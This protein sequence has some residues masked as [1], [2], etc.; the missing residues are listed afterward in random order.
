MGPSIQ[1][2][3]SVNFCEIFISL[4]KSESYGCLC[5]LQEFRMLIFKA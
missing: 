4:F 1:N 3:L 5:C 2:F